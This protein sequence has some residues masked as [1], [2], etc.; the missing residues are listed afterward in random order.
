MRPYKQCVEHKDI[1]TPRSATNATKLVEESE[2]AACHTTTSVLC[3]ALRN[4][5]AKCDESRPGLSHKFEWNQAYLATSMMLRGL[6]PLCAAV[7]VLL[8][9]SY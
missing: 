6:A 9:P 4:W 3:V 8:Y 1:E 7:V 2:T 5:P